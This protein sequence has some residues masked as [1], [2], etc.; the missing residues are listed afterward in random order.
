MRHEHIAFAPATRLIVAI[1]LAVAFSMFAGC[2]AGKGFDSVGNV[3]KTDL[4]GQHIGAVVEQLG[5]PHAYYVTPDGQERHL[6]YDT[7]IQGPE[8][9]TA[10]CV[11]LL[12]VA[13]SGGDCPTGGHYEVRCARLRFGPDRRLLDLHVPY[14]D[15]DP[16]DEVGHEE[17]LPALPHSLDKIPQL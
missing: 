8:L 3:E 1:A 6:A 5:E 4:I 10:G 2:S 13:G 11:F 12:A 7:Y 17:F 16:C 15:A 9:S 14:L